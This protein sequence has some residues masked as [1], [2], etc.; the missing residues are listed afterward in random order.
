MP[1]DFCN[2]LGLVISF[3]KHCMDTY[4]KIY[5]LVVWAPLHSVYKNPYLHGAEVNRQ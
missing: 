4:L 3:S 1:N 2:G 5:V